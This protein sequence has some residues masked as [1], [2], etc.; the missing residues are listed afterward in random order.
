VISRYRAHRAVMSARQRAGLLILQLVTAAG[1]AV[2]AYTHADLAS[3]YDAV[4][5]SI[6]QGALFRIEAGAASAAALIVLVVGGRIGFALAALVA[7]SALGAILLY[8]Y[9]DVGSLGPLPNMYE[10][11]WFP[12]KTT[13]AI[14][15]T[16]ATVAAASGLGWVVRLGMRRRPRA[17]P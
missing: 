6:S 10:P 15:E 16:V 11:V 14:A 5:G 13:A 17:V 12:E 8:R 3:T 9:V 2:D 4:Q 7:A 1:L